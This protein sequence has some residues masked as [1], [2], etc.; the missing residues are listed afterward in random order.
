MSISHK[1]LIFT[2]CCGLL[3][4][5]YL[6]QMEFAQAPSPQIIFTWQAHN[7]YPSNYSGKAAAT[8][9]TSIVISATIIQ[10]NKFIDLSKANFIWYMD[11]RFFSRGSGLSEIILKVNKLRGDEY[12]VRT[13]IDLDGEKIE[14]SFTIPI[15]DQRTVIEMPYPNNIVFR[16]RQIIFHA[17]PYFFNVVSFDNFEFFWSIDNQNQPKQRSNRLVLSIGD[18]SYL[19]GEEVLISNTTS[20]SL[21][22][23]ETTRTNIRFTIQ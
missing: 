15:L 16:K 4:A 22:L 8:I 20:N 10:D 6:L 18:S 7:F 12:F 19:L 21:N 9:N 14:D 1:T 17:V 13:S 3:V 11:G 23:I 2:V 5:G